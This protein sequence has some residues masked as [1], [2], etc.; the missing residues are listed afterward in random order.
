M[1]EIKKEGGKC[2]KRRENERRKKRLG[3]KTTNIV[4]R[5][6]QKQAVAQELGL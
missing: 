4:C 3:K 2:S 6:Q 5:L 1:N